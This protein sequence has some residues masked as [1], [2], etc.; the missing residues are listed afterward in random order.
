MKMERKN[1]DLQA[2][3][4]DIVKEYK[5]Y[6]VLELNNSHTSVEE[7]LRSIFSLYKWLLERRGI[8]ILDANLRDI[9]EYIYDVLAGKKRN[10]V[11]KEISAIKS[12]FYFLEEA[13]Y[14]DK[15]PVYKL[16]LPKKERLLPHPITSSDVKELLSVVKKLRDKA[17]I[18]LLY[19]SGIRVS[20]LCNI[21]LMDIDFR[22]KTIRVLGK[23]RKE[24]I[25]Y[26]GERATKIIKEYI[27]RERV[28]IKD[29]DYVFPLK[30]TAVYNIV[31]RAGRKIGL[32][33]SPHTLR[34]TYATE[35]LNLDVDLRTIQEELG[36][37]SISTTQIYL[38]VSTVNQK[39]KDKNPLDVIGELD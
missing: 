21:R 24:R 36:H 28:G 26:I 38:K 20:E 11:S 15:N 13:G 1:S 12:F 34:H 23:G 39:Y 2:F 35:R 5:S 17:I 32:D 14:I 6:Q 8:F 3:F 27:S 16:R 30:R 9:R 33:I 18:S 4:M 25:V 22:K 31:N 19:A 10:T 37:S 7:Y 29:N